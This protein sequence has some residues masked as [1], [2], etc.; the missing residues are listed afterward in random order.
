KSAAADKAATDIVEVALGETVRL[1]IE[2]LDG[3]EFMQEAG[4]LLVFPADGGEPILLQNFLALGQTD[5]PPKIE[6]ENGD[7]VEIDQITPLVQ[8]YNL[9][10]IAPAAG[11]TQAHGG[12]ASFRS[13]QDGSIGDPLDI[14]DLLEG[15]SLE[16]SRDEIEEIIGVNQRSLTP[17]TPPNPNP[18]PP[19][20]STT[21]SYQ[22]DMGAG[23]LRSGGFEDWQPGQN[24]GDMTI[25]PM[26]MTVDFTPDTDEQITDIEISGFPPGTRFFVGGTA[27]GN[28]IDVTG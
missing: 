14:D 5:N 12:G 23:V 28:E 6:F 22:T 21:I 3:T 27:P 1:P 16:F 18:I 8:G 2:S 19:G 17:G 10:D 25:R 4:N 11:D 20:G 24:T 26:Q 13:Y 9:A 7:V 15:T